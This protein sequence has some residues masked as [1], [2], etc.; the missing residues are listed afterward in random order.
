MTNATQDKANWRGIVNGK[1]V[2]VWRDTSTYALLHFI[3][4]DGQWIGEVKNTLA[5][6]VSIAKSLTA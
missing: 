2:E 6:V 4:I 5:V 3:L 1:T